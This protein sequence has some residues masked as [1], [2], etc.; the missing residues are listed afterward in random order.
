MLRLWATASGSLKI[1][2]PRSARPDKIISETLYRNWQ[3]K[4]SLFLFQLLPAGLVEEAESR[5]V[6]IYGRCECLG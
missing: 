3:I 5:I 4:G 1:K 6:S 2:G